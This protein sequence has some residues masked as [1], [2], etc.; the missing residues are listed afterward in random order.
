GASG[1]A[2]MAFLPKKQI[3]KAI[4]RHRLPAVTTHT[5]TSQA[6]LFREL[7]TVRRAGYAI[8]DGERLE[9]AVGIAAPVFRGNGDVFGSILVTIPKFRFL[10]KDE[11]KIARAV[12]DCA[13]R[14]VS[15]GDLIYGGRNGSR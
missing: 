13:A 11:S 7:A 5:I 14:L 2:V 10:K 9:Q 6:K 4:R 12:K 3:E 15:H 8:S 1:R